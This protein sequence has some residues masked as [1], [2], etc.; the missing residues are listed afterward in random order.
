MSKI[1]KSQGVTPTE[2]FLANLCDRTF[3]KLWSYPN[4]YKDDGQELCD[5]L[6]VFENHVFIFFDRESSR[7]S[8]RSKDTDTQW[9]R[10]KKEV[11]D[12]QVKTASGAARYIESGREIFLD[13]KST[14]PFPV[15]FDR[16]NAII[17]RIVIAHGAMEACA[18]A[19]TQNVYGSLGVSYASGQRAENPFTI[20]L[21]RTSATHVFDSHN[22]PIIL[23]ELDTI[24]D[25]KNYL[26]EKEK[27]IDK[28]DLITYAGEEDLLAHYILNYND[29]TASRHIGV[30]DPNINGIWI[31]EGEWAALIENPIYLEKK[32]ADKISYLW[33][34]LLQRT[35]QYALDGALLGDSLPIHS[36]GAIFEMAKESRFYRR[37]LSERM[38]MAI[39]SFPD[40]PGQACRNVSL[41]PS[42]NPE[43][44]YV[45]LQLFIADQGDD[46]AEYRARR[47]A[48]LEV[49]CGAA[50]N[51]FPQFK[52]MIGIAIDA[53]KFAERNSE[54]FILMDCTEWSADLR[55]HYEELNRGFN[56]F[57]SPGLKPEHFTMNEYPSAPRNSATRQKVGRN[58]PCPCRSGK[59]HKK[60]CLP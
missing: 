59:K 53:P 52:S 18:S 58:A 54:D 42:S 55:R 23:G 57:E 28:Y 60:C 44:A 31:E 26:E 49:A 11:V 39:N 16:R 8:D 48:L 2:A 4:P 41:I 20:N 5:V 7:L 32:S 30:N 10:W 51:K 43:A 24:T 22:L 45:F 19:S 25:F 47:Q 1:Q 50:K 33:D 6:A 14:I 38:S 13:A 56:F 36:E 15:E 21:E 34:E 29:K 40:E 12:K 46:E 35:A 9:L 3:L 17:H 37:M 27:A